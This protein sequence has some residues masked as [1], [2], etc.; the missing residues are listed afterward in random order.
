MTAYSD[1]K[2]EVLRATDIVSLV[3]QYVPLSRSGRT[4]KALCPFHQEKTPSFNVSPERQTWKCFGCGKGG[5][6]IDFLIE[7]EKVDFKTALRLLA[8][9]AGIRLPQ[10]GSGDSEGGTA[11]ARLEALDAQKHAQEFL[12]RCFVEAK[13]A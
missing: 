8:D 12:R 1:T 4:F 2:Q 5:N 11:A 7:R 3:E 9:K 6:A 13:Q 10:R